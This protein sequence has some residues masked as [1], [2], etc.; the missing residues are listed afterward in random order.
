[1][2][3]IMYFDCRS[4]ISGDM[5]VGALLDLGIDRE[6]FLEQLDRL[7]LEGAS[8]QI[9]R[10]NAF[11]IMA[12]DFEVIMPNSETT[13]DRRNLSDIEQLIDSSDLES[14]V[15][16][17]SKQIF[18]S[19]AE[20]E[21]KVHGV[22]IEEIHF[23]EIGAIDSIVDIVGTSICLSLLQVDRIFASPLHL[24]RGFVDCDHGT[25]PIPAPATVEILR[26]VPVYSTGIEGEL[27]TPTG[28]A[29]IT[30]LTQDFIDL[31]PMVVE[32]IGYGKGKKDYSIPNVLRVFLG[33]AS[34][35]EHVALDKIE[36]MSIGH[37]EIILL[38]TNIDDLSP[39]IYSYLLPKLLERG[40]LDV[41][42]TNI[43]MK[44]G[45]PGVMLSVLCDKER[46]KELEELIFA[47]TTTLGIRSQALQRQYL[48]RKIVT[49]DSRFGPIRAKVA[50]KGEQRVWV[51]PEYEACKKIAEEH[52]LPLHEVYEQLRK[53]LLE[54]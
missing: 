28:A 51:K 42:L 25:L 33:R 23:H 19:I 13:K 6:A 30:N 46:K 50:F 12:T 21:S 3:R 9:T 54:G 14:R 5:T 34:D 35:T 45:R 22:P 4:G 27:V 31:P 48:E 11:G 29:I 41:F 37:E 44:K 10:K 49:L 7:D 24:G 40:A 43:M 39:E 15:K 1:M 32:T 16:Q 36:G 38:E 53:D 47:E 8:I 17:L 2:A 20:A 18:R 52:G 26:G